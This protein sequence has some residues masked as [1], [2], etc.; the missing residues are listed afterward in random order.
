MKLAEEFGLAPAISERAK[1]V[2][3]ACKRSSN[4]TSKAGSSTLKCTDNLAIHSLKL[5]EEFN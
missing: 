1:S 5:D 4:A 3:M 2:K